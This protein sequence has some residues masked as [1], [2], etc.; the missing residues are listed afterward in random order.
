MVEPHVLPLSDIETLGRTPSMLLSGRM[1]P[2]ALLSLIR[3]KI[4][5]WVISSHSMTTT[6][7]SSVTPLSSLE[8]CL[9]HLRRFPA[10]RKLRAVAQ[11]FIV[12]NRMKRLAS[13]S[14]NGEAIRRYQEKHTLQ[15]A[16]FVE[17]HE[18]P[19]S[20]FLSNFPEGSSHKDLSNTS[21]S[22]WNSGLVLS[23]WLMDFQETFS[24]KWINSNLQPTV[25]CSDSIDRTNTESCQP[26]C[27][28]SI[29]FKRNSSKWIP[30]RWFQFCL[31]MMR[32]GS[33]MPFLPREIPSLWNCH[34]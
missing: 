14:S 23:D 6:D 29:A 34:H 19:V 32:Q 20:I 7:A 21:I 22:E 31:E 2:E 18:V 10:R 25:W 27:V 12:A 17:W 3:L 16:S 24:S 11:V 9:S 33:W 8:I 28:W 15:N 1:K 13:S 26:L 4:K 5:K 30:K